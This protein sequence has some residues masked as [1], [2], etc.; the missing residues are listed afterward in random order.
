MDAKEAGLTWAPRTSL[1]PTGNPCPAPASR[2]CLPAVQSSLPG[3][4]QTQ[5]NE[6]LP[7]KD[8]GSQALP[9]TTMWPRAVT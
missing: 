7:A 9:L 6:R 8:T 5:E 4:E 1:K 3:T 2:L